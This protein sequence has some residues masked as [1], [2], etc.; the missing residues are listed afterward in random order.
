MK[1]I[2]LLVVTIFSTVTYAQNYQYLG[3]FTT[4][5]TPLYLESPGDIV[6]QETMDMINGSLPEGYPVPD[7]NP[8]YISAGYDTDVIINQTADVWVTFVSE[9]AGYRNVLGFYTYDVNNPSPTAPEP[10]DI[11]IVFPNASAYGSGGGLLTGDKV[12]IGNFS[13]GTGI[14]WVLLANAWDPSTSA[15]GSG[16]WQLYSNTDY[17]PEAEENLRYHNV[18]LNDPENERVILGFEDIRRDWASCDNDF[19]DAIFYVTA[20]PYEAIKTVNYA[21]VASARD[22]SSANDGGLESNGNLAQAIAKRNLKRQQNGNV[23]NKKQ[24][25]IQYNKQ[26]VLAM[27]NGSDS[28]DEV[29]LDSYLPET[30]MYGTES[31]YISSPTDLLSITNASE[32]FSVDFYEA[33]K[34]VSAVLATATQ[35]AV[36]D[37]SKVICDRLNSSS[38]EDVRTV[39]VRGHQV[40]SS[41]LVRASG[42]TE[43]SLSF[44]VKLGEAS[45]ELF[46]FWNIAQYPEGNYYN[47]QIWGSSF[48]QVFSIGNHIIDTLTEEKPLTSQTLSNVAPPVFVSSGYYANGN[49]H[50]NIINKI[51]ATTVTFEGSIATTEVSERTTNTQ[52]LNL[53]GDWFESVT[54]T[55]GQ[56]FDIGF[57]LSTDSAAQQDALYLADGP[58]GL[59]YQ[60]DAVD[61]AQF[62]IANTALETDANLYPVEREPSVTGQAKGTINLFRHL[63]AGD[64]ALSVEAYQ[65]F[66]FEIQNSHPVEV[67]LVPEGLDDWNDRLRYV[68]PTHAE[69]TLYSIP[70]TDFV[71]G[72]GNPALLTNVKTIVFSLHGNYSTYAPFALQVNQVAFNASETL[73]IQTVEVETNLRLSAYPNPMI[74]ETTIQ[75]TSDQSDTV[76]VMVYDQLGKIVYK[77]EVQ[78]A[79]GNNKIVW[80]KESL[81]SGIYIVKVISQHQSYHPLKLI[82]K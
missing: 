8:H 21:D 60:E 47:F 7:F 25:Q 59:D 45:N 39:M 27:R 48:S 69:A 50:L 72:N 18:L 5:G 61:V 9:G 12:N 1:Q 63:L 58:W 81:N 26:A 55:T 11:T 35:G 67:I 57:S 62:D 34:R 10:E 73:H 78:I 46:S 3:D 20:N 49:L 75:L 17:N 22:V 28:S 74:A 4:E 23:F 19:N 82:A 41:K 42:E 43:F 53:S 14:G 51:N 64:Q 65:G 2:L 77:T 76:T 70:F 54:I 33:D 79:T 32:I 29:T 13:P 24:L 6:S 31:A 15:V 71:D 37:H 80:K 16:L 30:G 68:V 44:S 40:I 38:L 36:Y 56:L 66:Q 52:I